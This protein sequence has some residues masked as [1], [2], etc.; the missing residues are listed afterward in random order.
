MNGGQKSTD[1]K[2]IKNYLSKNFGTIEVPTTEIDTE[3]TDTDLEK[4]TE[5]YLQ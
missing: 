2:E 1:R 4:A 5:E 3:I